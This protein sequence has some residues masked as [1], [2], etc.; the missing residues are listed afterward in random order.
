MGPEEAR[1]FALK[2]SIERYGG[3][4]KLM[5]LNKPNLK[6]FLRD[7]N[8]TEEDLLKIEGYTE[9]ALNL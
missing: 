1:I 9:T 6:A 2:G 4:N 3:I 7:C 8:C 5:Q